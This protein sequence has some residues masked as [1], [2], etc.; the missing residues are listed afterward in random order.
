MIFCGLYYIAWMY[1][2][3]KWRGYRIRAEIVTEE[4]G[5]VAAH[6]LVKVPEYDVANWD[7]TH[8]ESGQ[9]RQRVV[10]SDESKYD[11]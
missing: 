10:E 6:R 1:L 4:N 11:V 9:L 8:D 5:K 2:L 7:A 3:P